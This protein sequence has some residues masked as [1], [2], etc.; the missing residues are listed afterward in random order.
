MNDD[1]SWNE[2]LERLRPALMAFAE[3]QSPAWLRSKLDPSDLV[4]QT[5]LECVRSRERIE[6][7]AEHEALA[8]LRRALNNNLIDATRK[9]AGARAEVTPDLFAESSSG[10]AN[11]LAAP[12]TSPSERAVRNERF[13]RLAS[14]LAQ[15]PEVQR[16]AVE[17]RFLRGLKVVQIA[18]ILARSEGAVA[19][20]L[21]RAIGTLRVELV[22]PQE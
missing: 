2:L 20:L 22:E 11:W 17:L 12:D 4:Q 18:Q 7:C 15:L 8:Y 1:S 16:I 5:L 6:G 13:E 21:H 3:A 19:L 14:S 10:L 9:F